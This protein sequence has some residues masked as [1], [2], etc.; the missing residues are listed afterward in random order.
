MAMISHPEAQQKAQEEIDRVVSKDRV[1]NFQDQ[2]SLPYLRA[3]C[4][5]V[6]RWRPVSS[7]GFRHALTSDVQYGKYVLPKGSAI[8]GNHWYVM[9][10]KNKAILISC[11]SIHLD[12]REYKNPDLFDPS[13]FLSEDGQS[14]RGTWFSPK[15]HYQF[16]FGRR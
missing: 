16:G 10:L 6:H 2:D 15:G 13:R 11:R 9:K 3:L 4:Q 5:E 14:V 12:P 7:G 1:P 8:L